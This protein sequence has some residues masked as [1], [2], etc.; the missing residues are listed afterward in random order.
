[1]SV[2]L[3]GFSYGRFEY[4]KTTPVLLCHVYMQR[5][6]QKEIEATDPCSQK[7]TGPWLCS[8]IHV[9]KHA[10]GD[11]WHPTPEDIREPSHGRVFRDRFCSVYVVKGV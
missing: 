1:M 4:V 5:F 9:L 8:P 7:G 11:S 10:K 3:I 2:F 6:L